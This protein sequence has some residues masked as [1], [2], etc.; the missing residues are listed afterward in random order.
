VV[1]KSIVRRYVEQRV[2]SRRRRQA[3]KRTSI[4]ENPGVCK[5]SINNS[6]ILKILSVFKGGDAWKANKFMLVEKNKVTI[7]Y[8]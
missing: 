4:Y 7:V 2:N 3:P 5:D 1:D 8:N 6:L